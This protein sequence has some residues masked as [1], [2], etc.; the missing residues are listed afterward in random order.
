M[1]WFSFCIFFVS[2][3]TQAQ[4]LRPQQMRL[5]DSVPCTP[6][7]DQSQSPT[8]WVFGTNS[9]F[10]SDL[11]KQYGLN[12]DLSEMFIARY[13]YIDK[14]KRYL[15]TKGKTYFAGGGQFRD[16]LRI[17]NKYGIVPE[18]VYRGRPDGSRSHDHSMLDTAMKRY[19]NGLLLQGK[20]SLDENE[21]KQVNDTLDRYLGH[22]PERFWYR[23]EQYS[24]KSFAKEVVKFTDDYVELMSFADLPM[25][26]KCLLNDKFNWAG[27]S[28]YNISLTDFSMIVDTAL[29]KGWSIGWEGDVTE[30]AFNHYSGYA[31]LADSF[32]GYD[33]KR[34][35]D[36]RNEST[37]RDH[38]LHLTGIGRDEKNRKWYYLKNSWG[39]W[40]SQHKGFLF[41]N[42]D[43]FKLKTIIVMVNKKALPVQ[44][45][46]RLGL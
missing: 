37:E 30:K 42:E 28:L 19:I 17:V 12:L 7:K 35:Q 31:A 22:V 16:V 5:T 44:L 3:L 13:A 36:F 4:D 21:L 20:T 9:L 43:Y 6:V 39:S 40:L 8:C 34:L 25:N 2:T 23:G 45:K 24:P 15:A 26:K 1:R 27:D 41:M 38:M 18:E 11:I 14:A 46:A 32:Y 10:E 29:A 33:E